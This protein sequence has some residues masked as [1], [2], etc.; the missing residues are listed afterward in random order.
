MTKFDVHILGCGSATPSLRHLPAC[1]VVD[2]RD[3]LLM[4][5]CGEGAQ[6]SMRRQRLKFSRL[7]DIFI[8]HLH[9]DHFLGLPGLL[10]TLALHEEGGT[11]TVHIAEDGARL[12][13]TIM[14]VL[15]RET[16]FE[17]RY[18]VFDPSTGGVVL[19]DKSLK[20][21]AFPLYH[22]V[23][24]CGFRFEEKPKPRH[25]RGDMVKFHNVPVYKMAELK[26]GADF[27]T[28]DG[29]IIAN[30]ALTTDADPSASYA[31]CSD[32]VYDERVVEAVRG[33]DVLYHESTYGD[34]KAANAAPRGHSTARQAAEVARAAGVKKLILGHFSKSY[35]DETPLV[36]QARE[37]FPETYAATE[38]MVIDIAGSACGE[39]APDKV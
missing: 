7:T 8:S 28:P 1:Q 37:I 14:Q 4:V 26:A 9:G 32:T 34:D 16:S 23:P 39:G 13:K 30:A 12:L 2:F 19:D 11:I 6:L 29:R 35:N 15:C 33:V 22:R 21:T 24:C 18:D 38:G 3:R 27:V 36:E 5:D 10:S 25:I 20:V 17:L 31:Y